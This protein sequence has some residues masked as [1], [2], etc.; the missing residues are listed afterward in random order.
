MARNTT[1]VELVRQLRAEVGQAST[2]T[3][4]GKDYEATLIQKLQRA[5]QML[6]DDYDWPFLRFK[7]VIPLQ[8]G[9]RY[10]DFPLEFSNDF[11]NAFSGQV[12]DF[13][14]IEHA[15]INYSG[16]PTPIERG[17]SWEQYAQY[18]SDNDERSSPA[19]RWDV[20]R[21]TDPKEQ[22]EIWPI[23]SDDTQLFELT[24]IKKL[25][26]LIANQDKA[27]IDD[28]LLVSTVAYEILA[29]AKSADAK[30]MGDI[31]A[32]RI[33]QLKGRVKGTSRTMNMAGNRN[34]S[35]SNRGKTIIRIG[36][37]TN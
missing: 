24:G 4:I 20:K 10:Y 17:I 32:A 11:D 23:P 1:L 31:A 25:R 27:D 16:K 13:E 35:L 12:L 8:S 9:L 6:Y 37:Q 21:T 15:T 30:V 7:W 2:Q 26:P 29:K 18:N 33:K 36:S 3:Q 34:N 19:R 22:I 28:I 5:Q 14:R